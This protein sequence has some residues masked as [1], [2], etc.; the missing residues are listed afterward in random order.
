MCETSALGCQM[1]ECWDAASSLRMYQGAEKELSRRVMD[2]RSLISW[3][4][5]TSMSSRLLHAASSWEHSFAH[6]VC[7]RL[8][9]LPSEGLV[10]R[11]AGS[12]MKYLMSSICQ[13]STTFV[14]SQILADEVIRKGVVNR[15]SLCATLLPPSDIFC[16]WP[17]SSSVHMCPQFESGFFTSRKSL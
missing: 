17:L 15:P 4:K 16:M 11:S 3:S 10:E 8:S 6:C 14:A 12:S 2:D 5:T 7:A 13:W 1:C 9:W